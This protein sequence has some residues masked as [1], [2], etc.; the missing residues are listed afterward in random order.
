M[1][2]RSDGDSEGF[3]IVDP[4]A[5]KDAEYGFTASKRKKNNDWCDPDW[6]FYIDWEDNN[7]VP[8]HPSGELL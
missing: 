7:Q 1:R 5:P 8:Y 6:Y 2:E 3:T 4:D